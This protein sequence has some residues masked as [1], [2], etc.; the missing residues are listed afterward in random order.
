M[1]IYGQLS[2]LRIMNKIDSLL[3]NIDL[4][5]G[6]PCRGALLV[7]EPFLKEKYFNHAVICLIDY[8]IGETSMGIVMN[9]MT[10]YTLS[11]LI[12]T[13]TRKE[14]I[15]I[16]CGGPMSCDRLYFIHT[17]G[18]IIPG[19]R[20]IC[21]GLYIGGDFDSM[22]DYVNS[23]YPVEGTIRFYLGY[24]GWGIGQLD[25]ELKDNVWAVT[26]ITDAD[27]I[28]LG[29]EDGYWHGQVRSMGNNYKGWL[30][31]PQNPRLN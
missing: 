21:P 13:V 5:K 4:P 31:H 15:P 6:V 27:S 12:S 19:A 7:A 28:L 14:P 3:F 2:T 30:Y 29:A 9:K 16:Y 24:S 1:Y 25:E 20:C 11:D 8:E 17:L 23:D 22:L 26:S 18:D 10:N